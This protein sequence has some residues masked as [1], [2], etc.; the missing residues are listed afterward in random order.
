MRDLLYQHSPQKLQFQQLLERTWYRRQM[1]GQLP[2]SRQLYTIPT[3]VH[4]VHNNGPGNITDAQVQ[5]AMS[6]LNDA[7]R[8]R[9]IFN[10]S[11]GV[12]VEIEFCLAVQDPNG[13]A[14]NG[15][16]RS[17]STL[18][19]FTM[20]TEDLLVKGLSRW[21]PT[22]YLNIWVVNSITSLSVGPGVAGY[23][24]F[25][26]SH[27]APEDGIVGE[28]S[29]FD[30]A[31]D[32]I[33]V[34]AHE[35][36]HYLGLYH[37][38]QGGCT[39]NDCLADGDRVC[40]T[41]PDAS[42]NPV[43]C[44]AT[45]NTCNTDSDDTNTRNPFRPTSM[46]GLGD[47]TDM[48]TNY[49]DYGDPN[50]YS[51]FTQGQKDRM[52]LALTGTRASLLQSIGCQSPCMQPLSASFAFGGLPV[53]VGGSVQLNAI[54]T[55]PVTTYNWEVNGLSFSQNQNANYT[56]PQVGTYIFNLVVE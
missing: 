42:T 46:G 22:Q 10:P 41:P 13:N 50:C 35:A 30:S 9:G 28:A 23:A 7:M 5:A 2:S 48:F 37:T 11:T 12:D 17:V 4:I 16:T 51:A 38:F 6:S 54:T 49:M 53:G 52:V 3:V 39:N 43:S 15:I 47:Q 14:T 36:G 33:S 44:T 56:F 20:E 45:P 29:Y 24:Y 26:S 1:S 32:K 31:N 55:G 8:N 25:P 21:D 40:D 34:F 27:G 18:T 19:D